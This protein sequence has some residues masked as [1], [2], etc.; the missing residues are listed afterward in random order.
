[1]HLLVLSA[2]RPV[3]KLRAWAD[4]EVSM[5]LLVLSAFR[6]NGKHIVFGYADSYVSMHL[7]VLSAFRPRF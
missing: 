5:H 7:L 3:G 6:R 4:L 1:M 2:F